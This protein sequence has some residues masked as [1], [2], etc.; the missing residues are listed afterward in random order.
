MGSARGRLTGVTAGKV[1][2]WSYGV[3]LRGEAVCSGE[4]RGVVPW[5]G[6]HAWGQESGFEPQPRGPGE[7]APRSELLLPHL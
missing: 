7:A 2:G 6:P 4:A 3:G 5:E 1:V